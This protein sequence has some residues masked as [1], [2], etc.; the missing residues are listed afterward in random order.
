MAKQ[1]LKYKIT[2]DRKGYMGLYIEENN[3]VAT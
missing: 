2:A 3:I 1:D